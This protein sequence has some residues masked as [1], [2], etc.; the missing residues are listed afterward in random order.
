MRLGTLPEQAFQLFEP[1]KGEAGLRA[2]MRLGRQLLGGLG[3]CP[4]H[5]S[6]KPF[7]PLYS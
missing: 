7:R 2:G 3:S 4:I 1:G 6:S 5:L